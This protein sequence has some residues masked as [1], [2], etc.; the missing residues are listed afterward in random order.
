MDSCSAHRCAAVKAVA[1]ELRIKVHFIPPGLTGLLQ[2]L[3]RS[4]FGAVKA[5]YRAIYGDDMSQRQDKRVSKADFAAFAILAWELVSERPST[6]V[7]IAT[8]PTARFWPRSWRV[9]TS[10]HLSVVSGALSIDLSCS[11]ATAKAGQRTHA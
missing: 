9:E 4:V 5:E 8:P 6:A 1:E 7:G 10:E 11:S 2:P 3:D